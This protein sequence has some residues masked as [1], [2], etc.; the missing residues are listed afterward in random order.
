MVMQGQKKGREIE[1]EESQTTLQFQ[2]MF[3]KA[4]GTFQSQVLSCVW[5]GWPDSLTHPGSVLYREE[6]AESLTVTAAISQL[7]ST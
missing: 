5:Q 3:V 6:P 1:E 2:E 4:N 7:G